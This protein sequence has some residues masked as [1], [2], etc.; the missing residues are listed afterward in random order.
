[1]VSDQEFQTLT[2]RPDL[3]DDDRVVV[4]VLESAENQALVASYVAEKR[5]AVLGAQVAE[6][7]GELGAMGGEG[8]NSAG[9][10]SGSGSGG[11]DAV[12]ARAVSQ[13]S[14]A[15]RQALIRALQQST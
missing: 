15:G 14:V 5:A 8:G 10:G 7:L 9:G 12:L 11:V 3:W 13:L 1:M 4:S 2:G 6:R